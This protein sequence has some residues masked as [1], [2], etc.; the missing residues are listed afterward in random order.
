MPDAHLGGSILVGARILG[1]GTKRIGAPHSG[2]ASFIAAHTLGVTSLLL[3]GCPVP[4]A[5]NPTS[6]TPP[7]LH[8]AQPEPWRGAAGPRRDGPLVTR[9]G[10]DRGQRPPGKRGQSPGGR[11]THP[12]CPSPRPAGGRA[13]RPAR[14]TPCLPCNLTRPGQAWPGTKGTACRRAAARAAP[15]PP[16]LPNLFIDALT[17]YVA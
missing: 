8:L 5:P 3:S 15:A 1:W 17:L 6:P 14:T 9:A 4:T 12:W 13:P 16:S 10:Q 7:P 11:E 2:K